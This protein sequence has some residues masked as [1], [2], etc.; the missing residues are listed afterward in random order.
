MKRKLTLSIAL[1]LSITFL[2]LTGSDSTAQSQNQ[3]KPVADTGVITLGPNQELRVTVAA[4]DVNGD[5]NIRVRFRKLEYMQTNCSNGVCKYAVSSQATSDPITLA[6]GEAA[7]R[8]W[9]EVDLTAFR[10]MVLSSSRN[11]RVTGIVFDTSTQRV[12]AI[13]VPQ[14]SPVVAQE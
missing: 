4:G 5:D 10:G 14:G 13:W 1:I 12:V 8:K 7:S 3:L 6:P 11:V 9:Y 2:L